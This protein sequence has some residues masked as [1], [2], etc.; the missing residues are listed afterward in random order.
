MLVWYIG[1]PLL[2]G[3]PSRLVELPLSELDAVLLK[4]DPGR[5]IETKTSY[6][7]AKE[8]VVLNGGGLQ[9]F[10]YLG[11]FLQYS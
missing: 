7:L 5:S 10:R 9:G 4:R 11:L 1:S 3:S 6:W 8:A 2:S